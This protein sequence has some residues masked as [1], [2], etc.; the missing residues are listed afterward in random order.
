MSVMAR[1]QKLIANIVKGEDVDL[2]SILFFDWSPEEARVLLGLAEKA[3]EEGKLPW[4]DV[5][6]I[7]NHVE[8]NEDATYPDEPV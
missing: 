8:G 6:I 3:Y 1:G 4:V 7:N 5:C 2:F